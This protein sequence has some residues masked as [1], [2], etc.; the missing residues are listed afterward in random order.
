MP[1]MSMQLFSFSRNWSSRRGASR[2]KPSAS[3]STAKRSF[4]SK[5]RRASITRDMWDTFDHLRG[6]AAMEEVGRTTARQFRRIVFDSGRRS[7]RIGLG[8]TLHCPTPPWTHGNGANS[9]ASQDAFRWTC[10]HP[11]VYQWRSSTPGVRRRFPGEAA[12]VLVNEPRTYSIA[13][14]SVDGDVVAQVGLYTNTLDG[15]LRGDFAGQNRGNSTA[16]WPIPWGMLNR[17]AYAI[18]RFTH[19]S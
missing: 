12:E 10:W 9:Y 3:H 4:R 13:G 18:R 17:R 5:E 1:F 11:G 15:L 2:S 14:A 8:S 6:R 7:S 19:H 16:I